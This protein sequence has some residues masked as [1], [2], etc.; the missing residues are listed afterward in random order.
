MLSLFPIF[1]AAG[2]VLE[3]SGIILVTSPVANRL[4]QRQWSIS[5][6]IIRWGYNWAI[7][8]NRYAIAR[9]KAIMAK[10][11]NIVRRR[12]KLKPPLQTV[13]INRPNSRLRE[14]QRRR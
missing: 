4:V 9:V 13:E 8:I 7:R 3:F 11:S 12:L 14:R 2:A 5:K 6:S 1:I 10:V